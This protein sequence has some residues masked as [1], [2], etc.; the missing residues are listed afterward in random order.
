MLYS[1]YGVKIIQIRFSGIKT[2]LPH[3]HILY[4]L[5][6]KVTFTCELYMCVIR[7]YLYLALPARE[8]MVR[9]DGGKEITQNRIIKNCRKQIEWHKEG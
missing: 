3:L 7:L 1:K 5:A 8:L 9:R 2:H 4:T 6:L